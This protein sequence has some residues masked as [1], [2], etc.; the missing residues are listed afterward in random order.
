MAHTKWTRRQILEAGAAAAAAPYFIPARVL[1]LE[2]GSPP[3]ESVRVGVIGCG[4]RARVINEAADVR[5]FRV[6]AACDR[7]TWAWRRE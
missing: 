7:R 2:D 5:P 3:S 1:G 6:V 4:G